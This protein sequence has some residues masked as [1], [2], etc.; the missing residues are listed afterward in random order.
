MAS[1]L[2]V[3]NPQVGKDVSPN[4]RSSIYAVAH[5]WLQEPRLRSQKNAPV[6]T[7]LVL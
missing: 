7:S 4:T 6:G 2:V 5:Q 1:S 3:E